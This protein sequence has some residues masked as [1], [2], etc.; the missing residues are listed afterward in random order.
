MENFDIW[1]AGN[2]L[3]CILSQSIGGDRKI[4]CSLRSQGASIH[5]FASGPRKALGGPAYGQ[6]LR[7]RRICWEDHQ[8]Q[9]RV[10]EL[11][12]WPKEGGYEE[13]LIKEQIDR[14]RRSVY[15]IYLYTKL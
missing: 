11:D 14:L 4:P 5:R 13:S 8:F 12:G 9:K 2:A 3:K 1:T 6:A 15:D 7:F 10:S